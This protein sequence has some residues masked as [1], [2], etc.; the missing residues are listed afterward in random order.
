ME[1]NGAAHQPLI[2]FKKDYD[3]A[4]ME[5]L[6]G[7]VPEIGIDMRL[8]GLIKVWLDETYSEVRIGRPS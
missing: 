8:I 4:G 2:G 6:Y 7:T 1:Y 5:T 3:S